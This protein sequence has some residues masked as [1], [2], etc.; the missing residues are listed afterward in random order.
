M[1][2][3]DCFRPTN[4]NR[5]TKVTFDFDRVLCSRICEEERLFTIIFLANT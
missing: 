4:T 5:E 1:V 2:G 3:P